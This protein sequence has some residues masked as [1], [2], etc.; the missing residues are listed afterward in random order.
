MRTPK[1]CVALTSI[2]QGDVLDGYSRQAE[3]EEISE[4]VRF[5]VIAD[6]KSPA[7]LYDKCK[8]LERLGFDVLC[9]ALEEQEEYLRRFGNLSRL[10][11][12]N[13]DNRRNIGYL[14][15]LESGCDVLI[16]LDDDNYCLNAA[17]AYAE[18]MVVSG[19]EQTLSTVH[20]DN[21]WY[22]ACDLLELDSK[23]RVYPRGFPYHRRHQESKVAFRQ[24]TGV[25][26]LNAGLWLGEPDLDAL[27]WLV[28]P[29]RAKSF[30]GPSVLLGENTWSPINTQNTSLHRD[31]IISF[32]FVPMAHRVSGHPIER[33]GD[34]FAGYF[35]QKCVRH[36]GHRIRV[37]TPVALHKRNAHDYFTDLDG[38]IGCI[39]LL[40]DL[41]PWLEEVRLE[42][43]TYGD[44]YLSLA[45]AMEDQVARFQG[46]LWSPAARSYFHYMAYCMRQWVS[47][48][49]MILGGSCRRSSLLP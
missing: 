36:L 41:M 9:P 44:A 23:A 11:P 2:Y 20:A 43:Q 33:Y 4:L 6:R 29:V 27:T 21:G 38:E 15:A 49:R 10:I 22:N 46:S 16:S 47:A 26:R 45:A 8:L 5:I 18:Y 14:M 12:Y 3:A 32:Y 31:L 42:G 1:V 30:K 35:C 7:A 24:E 17:N 25:I 34:I 19:G 39:R 37:G 48:C 28:T 13:S 40:E